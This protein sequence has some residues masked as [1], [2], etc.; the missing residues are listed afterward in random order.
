MN[1]VIK[2]L[3]IIFGIWLIV[4]NAILYVFAFVYAG[5]LFL[6]S[7]FCIVV[8]LLIILW[9]ITNDNQ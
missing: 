1:I 5:F 6:F 4:S 3:L 7:P 8:L 9:S 2:I